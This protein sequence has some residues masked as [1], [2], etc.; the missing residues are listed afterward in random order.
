MNTFRD[1]PGGGLGFPGVLRRVVWSIA[2]VVVASS[3]GDAETSIDSAESSA[4]VLGA[5]T[6][7]ADAAAAESADRIILT[8]TGWKGGPESTDPGLENVIASFEA[9]YPSVDVRLRHVSRIDSELVLIPEIE[10]GD[11]PDVMMTDLPLATLLSREDRLVDLGTANEWYRRISER[12]RPILTEDDAIYMSPTR[13]SPMAHFVN[14]ALL[15]EAG[16]EAAPTTIDDLISTCQK[17]DDNG[18]TPMAF[19]G[20]FSAALFLIANGLQGATHPPADYGTGE[21]QFV[22][23]ASF[24]NGI[25]AIR[26]LIEARCFDPAAQASL[27]PWSTSMQLFRAEG[28]AMIPHGGWNIPGLRS[29]GLDFVLAPIPT[30]EETGAVFSLL[31]TGWSIPTDAA[32]LKEARAFVNWMAQPEQVLMVIEDDVSVSPYDDGVRALAPRMAPYWEAD[33]QGATL[34]YPFGV[35]QWPKPLENEIWAS[36]NDFLLDTSLTNDEVLTRWDE[37]VAEAHDRT[38]DDEGAE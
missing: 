2:L 27:D 36:L 35:L 6:I 26:E 29:D 5:V 13:S 9:A 10:A 38:T 1:L 23:E 30:S 3:C 14:L 31:A 33:E 11:S 32:H 12:L 8:V 34:D 22:D 37:A 15:R 21:R 7:D 19:T 20:S 25:D 16:I 28:V 24:H 18:V 4:S 17:L